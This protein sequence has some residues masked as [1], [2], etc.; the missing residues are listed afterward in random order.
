[1][2]G[3][4]CKLPNIAPKVTEEL[5]YH[6]SV[7]DVVIDSETSD[8]SGLA[9][10]V[11]V[12]L[13][14]GNNLGVDGQN[15]EIG[16]AIVELAQPN[17]TLGVWQYAECYSNDINLCKQCNNVSSW[18]SIIDSLSESHSLFLPNT[19]CLR[20]LRRSLYSV[21]ASWLRVKLWDGNTD[22]YISPKPT[23]VRYQQ[24]FYNSTLP[25]NAIGSTSEAS[26]LLTVLIVPVNSQP[27]FGI[28]DPHLTKITE[29]VKLQDN[30]GDTVIDIVES[31]SFD[32]LPVLVSKVVGGLPELDGFGNSIQYINLLPPDALSTYY[33]AI[34]E[35]NPT[36]VERQ[37]TELEPSIAIQILPSDLVNGD[38]QV[39]MNG[40]PQ[41]YIYLS[42]I[43]GITEHL[44][45]LSTS[46]RIRFVPKPYFKGEAM[47]SVYPWDGVLPEPVQEQSL[48]DIM[49][50]T[51]AHG[52]FLPQSLNTVSYLRVDVTQVEQ[53]PIINTPTVSL[54][55]IPY[56]IRFNYSS[57]FTITVLTPFDELEASVV[58]AVLKLTD[59]GN[60][61]TIHNILPAFNKR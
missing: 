38:W 3:Q 29:N 59:L 47:L 9:K 53:Q 4:D 61:F 24:P 54:S 35:V 41:L 11:G 10:M 18:N 55:A 48:N 22:G 25:Y 33:N 2:N 28:S 31:I 40:D 16:I 26:T 19:A 30:I 5:I 58:E 32:H 14:N 6:S 27:M 42:D 13:G 20:Y 43:V 7:K 8:V 57:L 21:G 17:V 12:L 1:M 49:I 44:I 15:E 46:S 23:L 45:L 52:Y 51:T 60:S 34:D 50:Q 37:S 56:S 36:R 39:S